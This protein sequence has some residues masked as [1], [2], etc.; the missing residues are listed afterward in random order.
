MNIVDLRSDTV[1]LPSPE[2]KQAMLTAPLGDDVLGEDPTVN[3]LEELAA[4]K[5]C[6]EA[7]LF[8]PTGTMGNVCAVLAH[9]GR[10]EEALVG[11]RSH[12]YHWEAGGVSV[13]GGV[14]LHPVATRS[15]G[16]IPLKE[17]AAAVRNDLD[18]HEAPTRLVCLESSHN[19]CGGPVLSLDYLARAKTLADDRGM[20]VHLD[21]ARL[22]NA[23]RYL[24]L[25]AAVITAR[26]DS[27]MFCLS[28]GLAAPVGSIVAGDGGMIEKARRLRK[29]LGG[30]MRQAG[31]IAAAGIVA[32][33]RMTDRLEEDH[34]NARRLAEAIADEP[35]FRIDMDLVQTNIV[36][37][38]PVGE[39]TLPAFIET[40]R[41]NGLLLSKTKTS[42]RAVTHYGIGAE[43][44]DRAAKALKVTAAEV[45]TG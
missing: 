28:K 41:K 3:R 12:I 27:V 21:G 39:V 19:E 31:V 32:L 38:E 34:L 9:C 17:L 33:E 29:M 6:K 44:I 35:A 30:G 1:T 4:E 37:F 36:C 24:G 8:V 7:A 42:L 45:Q 23:A 40:A 22:F 2:M 14:P 11:D 18:T 10:G 13:M 25:P 20:K 26:V 43:D 16:E 5:V 15:D